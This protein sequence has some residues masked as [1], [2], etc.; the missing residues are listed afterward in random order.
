[1]FQKTTKFREQDGSGSNSGITH[2]AV[3]PLGG[4]GD[5]PENQ[6]VLSFVDHRGVQRQLDAYRPRPL[7]T[8]CIHE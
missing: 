4:V 8:G 5:D 3:T 6:P 1:M 7:R 2:E